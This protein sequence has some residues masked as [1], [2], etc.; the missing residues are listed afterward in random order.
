[1]EFTFHN[2]YVILGIVQWFSLQLL[3]EK[4]LKQDYVAPRL[5][6][7]LQKVFDRHYELAERW[8]NINVSNDNGSFPFY[9]EYLSSNTDKT[10]TGLDNI[11]NTPGVL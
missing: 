5:K 2:S 4:L 1:M 9:L 10:F 6:S 7:S 3:Y 8:Q 11:S